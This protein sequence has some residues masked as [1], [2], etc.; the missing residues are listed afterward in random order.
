MKKLSLLVATALVSAS[1]AGLAFAEDHKHP[2]QVAWPFDGIFGRVDKQAAQRGF[3]V[4]KEVCSAC[5]G[6]GR[7]AFRNLTEIGFS[8]AE[9]KALA[10]TYQIKDGPNDEGEMFERAGLASDS[11]VPP[12]ANENAARAANGGAYPPDLSLIIKAR[13]DGANYVHSL[14]TGYEPAPAGFDMQPGQ[15]Y[16]PY[17]PGGRLAMPAPLNSE[18]QVSYSDGT[19]ATVEQMSSDVVTFLQ[20]AAEPEMEARKQGG[21]KVLMYLAIFTAFMYVAKR[22]LWKKLH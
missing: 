5:H 20:W 9:V 2:R 10:A 14:L 17:M 6:L 4:Y 1:A 3:Q 22:N 15:Y 13:H 12:F 8:E 16:N 7:V 21:I 18:G 11:F 19:K